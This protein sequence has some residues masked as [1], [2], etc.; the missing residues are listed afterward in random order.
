MSVEYGGWDKKSN[1]NSSSVSLQILEHVDERYPAE[2]YRVSWCI[3]V[4]FL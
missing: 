1:F 2:N 3:V 4:V